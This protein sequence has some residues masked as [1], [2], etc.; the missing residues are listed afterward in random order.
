MLGSDVTM[1]N[2]Q[3]S[4]FSVFWKVLELSESGSFICDF[5]NYKKTDY[6]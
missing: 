6:V 5:L 4:L 1:P 2:S 3:T